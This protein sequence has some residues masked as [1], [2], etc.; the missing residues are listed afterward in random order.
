MKK[1]TAILIA[2]IMIVG[3]LSVATTAMDEEHV[4]A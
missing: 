1:I 4:Q 3:I 2:V